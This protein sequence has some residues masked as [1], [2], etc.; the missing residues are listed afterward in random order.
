MAAGARGREAERISPPPWRPARGATIGQGLRRR[1][2]L[3]DISFAVRRGEVLMLVGENGAGKSTLKNILSGLLAPDAGEIRVRAARATSALSTA[4]ADRL[5]IGTIHQELSLF[6]N[7]SVAENIHLP[8]LPQ[9]G[10]FVDRRRDARRR[11]ARCC[12]TCSAPT[13][14]PTPRSSLSLGERQLVEIA[15][16][17]HRSSSLLILDE[18][19]TC[20]SLPERGACSPSCGGWRQG[21][22]IIYI[23][24]FM[25]EVYELGRPHRRAARRRRRRPTARRR[26]SRCRGWPG[27]MVGRELDDMSHRAA[28]ARRRTRRSCSPRAD[29]ADGELVHDVSFDLRA[30]EILGLAGLMG[31]GRSEIAEIL[32][33]LRA[34]AGEVTLDGRPFDRPL[35]ARGHGRGPRAGV[36]GPAPGPGLSRPRVARE[37]DRAASCGGSRAARCGLARSAIGKRG[38]RRG[39]VDEF[40]VQPSR[41]GGADGDACRAATSRRRSSGRWLTADPRVCILDEPTKGVDIGARAAMHRLIRRAGRAGRRLPADQFRP[42][43]AA[44]AGAPRAGAAQGPHRRRRS[45]AREAEPQRVSSHGLDRDGPRDRRRP[46][47]VADRRPRSSSLVAGDRLVCVGFALLTDRFADLDNLRN[48][49]LQAVADGDR[50]RRHDLRHRDRAASTC[51]SARSPT[52]RWRSRLRCR[53]AGRGGADHANDLA[54]LPGGARGGRSSSASLNAALIVR[55]RLSPLIATLGTLTLYRG[56]GLHL[57]SAALI[58]VQR[59]RP[60]VRP[61]PGRRHR[62]AGLVRPRSL[63]SLGWVL[64]ARTVGR[65]PGPGAGRVAALGRRDRDRRRRG[66]CSAVYG[67]PGL[68]GA[69]A[70]LI[71]VGRVGVINP[72]LGFGFEFTVITAVVLGGTSLFGGR[73]SDPRQRDGRRAADDHRQRPEPDRRQPLHLRRRARP[74]PAG[75]VSLGR[76]RRGTSASAGRAVIAVARPAI[77][78]EP[79]RRPCHGRERDKGGRR[80]RKS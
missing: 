46:Q 80:C 75:A 41:A 48:V 40:A 22:G 39:I 64:L 79:H 11:R 73:G 27:S 23:T 70:G 67:L 31:A 7:L 9:R 55:L 1:P 20:L 53:H 16:A 5:G 33:G 74:H 68:C 37:P 4:D 25:E 28:A 76:D 50:R 14:T 58:A 61:R 2:V 12:T 13:S 43:R 62:A 21:F 49:L 44:R 72:D 8:H 42:A 30:G 45:R 54:R 77:R 35:A 10:G 32:L 26:R 71:V 66:C 29:L 57:T 69:V 17:I 51:R 36:G 65:P 6:G 15:K 56:L 47:A 38:R 3:H 24:H 59:A 60:G 34:A 18:P 52:W 63:R 78:S 19:T